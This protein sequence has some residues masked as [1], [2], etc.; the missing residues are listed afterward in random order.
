MI[1]DNGFF[2]WIFQ[3][4]PDI[5]VIGGI[6]LTVSLTSKSALYLTVYRANFKWEKICLQ[7]KL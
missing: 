3:E 2:V 4:L 7:Q 6:L 5:P 1:R